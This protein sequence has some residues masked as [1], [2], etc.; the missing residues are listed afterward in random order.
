[1]Q[2]ARDDV[3]VQYDI[4]LLSGIDVDAGKIRSTKYMN[5]G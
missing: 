3:L 4:F 2:L 5:H 1:M